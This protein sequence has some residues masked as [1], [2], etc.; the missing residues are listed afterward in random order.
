MII[1]ALISKNNHA[2]TLIALVSNCIHCKLSS[3]QLNF[4]FLINNLPKS[5]T[6]TRGYIIYII[7]P[8]YILQ[9]KYV[10]KQVA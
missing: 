1:Y 6:I 3:L 9:V 4:Y 8:S 10:Q 7:F 2:Y 5:Q